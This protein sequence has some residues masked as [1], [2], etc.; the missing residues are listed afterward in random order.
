MTHKNNRFTSSIL[1]PGP[2]PLLLGVDRVP[3]RD[4]AL[5]LAVALGQGMSKVAIGLDSNIRTENYTMTTGT[6]PLH[7]A[8][9]KTGNLQPGKRTTRPSWA[10]GQSKQP[11][12]LDSLI[13]S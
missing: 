5:Q 11:S 3:L 4:F 12:E 2:S 13:G 6:Q 8:W 1:R 7:S 9:Q 10:N